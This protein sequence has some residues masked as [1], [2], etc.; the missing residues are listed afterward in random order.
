MPNKNTPANH[1]PDTTVP[2]CVPAVV[3][4]LGNWRIAVYVPTSYA[5]TG[6]VP[7]GYALGDTF[8]GT[9]VVN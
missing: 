2:P 3:T 1:V 7:T 8:L 6:Y 9:V 4:T 5:P